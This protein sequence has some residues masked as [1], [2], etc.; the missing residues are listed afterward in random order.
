[1]EKYRTMKSILCPFC[2]TE[3]A[4]QLMDAENSEGKLFYWLYC[5]LC[6]MSGPEGDSVKKA[7]KFWKK[8]AIIQSEKT[9][10]IMTLLPC[11]FCGSKSDL[12]IKRDEGVYENGIIYWAYCG[13]CKTTG[14]EGGTKKAARRAWNNRGG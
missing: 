14:P 5:E 3:S 10:S 1:M 7:E 4:V 9:Q 13:S 12:E 2:G 8:R 6:K 11:P